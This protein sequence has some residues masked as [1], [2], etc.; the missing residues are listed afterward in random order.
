M[1]K[2]ARHGDKLRMHAKQALNNKRNCATR[3]TRSQRGGALLVA[4]IMIF[5]LS[6]LG[7]SAMRGSTLERRMATNSIQTATTFQGAE[8]TSELALNDDN[9]LNQ[10]ILTADFDAVNQGNLS[11]SDKIEIN[12]TINQELGMDSQ[13]SLQ[14]VGRG[15]AYGFS[16]G[17]GGSKFQ[18]FRY[19]VQGGAKVDAI[20][21]RAAVTQGAYRIAP[22]GN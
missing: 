18:A 9:N 5:M 11:D 3:S 13:A 4:M 2:T 7:I 17:V 16:T 15:P 22:A 12:Y 19:E 6:I 21:A 10:A 20:R 14:Y 1:T 8:S